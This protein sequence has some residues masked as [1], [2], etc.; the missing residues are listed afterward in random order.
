MGVSDPLRQQQVLVIGLSTGTNMEVIASLR[1]LGIDAVGCT[2]LD[3]AAERH[4]ARAFDVIA[5]GRAALGPRADR[6]KRSF[7]DLNPAVRFVDALGPIAVAQV[8]AELARHPGYPARLGR[9]T[10]T[11][12]DHGGRVEATVL[13][14]CHIRVSLYFKA[15]D[16][17]LEDNVLLDVDRS[18]GPMTCRVTAEMSTAYSLIVEADLEEFH[19]FPFL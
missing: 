14:P 2:E 17:L 5:F 8:T 18:V 16:G 19:H 12:D 4:D 3:T 13:A 11:R 6:Q 7:V 15:S 1:H 10:F 9:V